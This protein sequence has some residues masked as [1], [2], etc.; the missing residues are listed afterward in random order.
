MRRDLTRFFASAEEESMSQ[1]NIQ[2]ENLQVL[3]G[4]KAAQALFCRSLHHATAEHKTRLQDN[5]AAPVDAAS[6]GRAGDP[7]TPPIVF[8]SVFLLPGDP[9]GP[10]QYSR[11]SNPTWTALEEA[12]SILEDAETAIFPSGMAAVAAVLCSQLKPGDRVLLPADAYYTSRVLADAYLAPAGVRV[13]TCPSA[14]YDQQDFAGFRMVWIETP[15]NP[16]L[17][18]CDLRK[19][20]AKAR[21]AGATV[22]AD[23]TLPTPLGQRPLDLGADLV[24]SSDSKAMNGHSDVVFGHV[25]SRNAGPMAAVRDWRKV[26]GAIP[27]PFESWL[28]HR[29]L[30]TL[31]VR[32]DRMCSNAE[33]LAPRLAEHPKVQEV[34]FPGLSSHPAHAVAKSQMLRFAM[35]LGVTLNDKDAAEKFINGCKFIRPTTSFGG[36]HTSAERR[37]RWGDKV[38]PGFVRLSVGCEPLE[39]LWKEMRRSLD[40][41]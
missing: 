15:S 5:G 3:H 12:L 23:N 38:P 40:N 18:I 30:E 31:E 4:Q 25:S 21:Q 17:E 41:V 8:S 1:R 28:V 34:K 27:G 37:A 32:F 29:G 16:G 11:W 33:A 22:I 20:V 2:T 9:A 10:Y 6:P 39:E 36:L 26:C 14:Q 13:L 35:I 19:A 24:V 7:V